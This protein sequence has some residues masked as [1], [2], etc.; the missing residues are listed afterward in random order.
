[1]PRNLFAI[2]LPGEDL[3]VTGNY[4][5]KYP[6]ATTLWNCNA[7]SVCSD[8]KSCYVN[9]MKYEHVLLLYFFEI[10]SFTLLLNDI[11]LDFSNPVLQELLTEI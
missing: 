10:L 1:M 5:I 2:K 6:A 4:F 7:V 3:L 9:E 8:I 11:A